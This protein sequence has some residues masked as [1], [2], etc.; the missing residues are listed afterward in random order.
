MARWQFRPPIERYR[1][2]FRL[3]LDDEERE[4]LRRLLGEMQGLLVGPNDNPALARVFP[5]AYHLP[6]H[7]EH[8][9][10]YQRLM[11]EELVASRLAGIGVISEALDA[12]PPLTE[13]QMNALMQGING[14]RLVLGTV[15]DVSEDD[16]PTEVDETHPRAGEHQLY[17]FLS[18]LLEW[19][20]RAM[21]ET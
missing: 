4:L 18:W 21:T 7:A 17:G 1:K 14:L 8:D 3:N 16:D 15:L 6:E 9:A 5:T 2:G 13:A 10:E 19:T 12:K 11:R 20:V